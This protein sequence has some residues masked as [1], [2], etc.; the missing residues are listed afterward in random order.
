[1]IAVHEAHLARGGQYKTTTD[2]TVT[3]STCM[4]LGHVT[5]HDMNNARGSGGG[6]NAKLPAEIPEYK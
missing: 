4:H 6:G 2:V 5:D 1:M 3:F